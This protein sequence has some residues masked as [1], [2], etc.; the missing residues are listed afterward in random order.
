MGR[1]L[2]VGLQVAGARAAASRLR[3]RGPR[4]DLLWNDTLI[5]APAD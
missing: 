2:F 5:R 4:A 3:R 1:F